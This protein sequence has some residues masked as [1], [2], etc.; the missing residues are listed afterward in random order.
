MLWQRMPLD[1][2]LDEENTGKSGWQEAVPRWLCRAL[3][4]DMTPWSKCVDMKSKSIQGSNKGSHRVP[5]RLREEFF[6]QEYGCG[7]A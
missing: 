5:T 4:I 6:K 3:S 1:Q 2:G 7:L